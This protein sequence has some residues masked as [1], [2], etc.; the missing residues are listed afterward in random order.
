M[1]DFPTRAQSSTNSPP[2]L[3]D[4]GTTSR[5]DFFAAQRKR[6]ELFNAT[7]GTLKGYHCPTCH[8]RGGYMTVEENGALRFQRC[9][10]CHGRDAA[11]SQNG[12]AVVSPVHLSPGRDPGCAW[13]SKICRRQ[14]ECTV[15]VHG[16]DIWAGEGRTEMTQEG[17]E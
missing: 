13:T 16:C 17:M 5:F 11:A 4:A 6:A 12:Y 9:R 15:S 14:M 10:R 2:R 3:T 1:Q 8:D 7:P